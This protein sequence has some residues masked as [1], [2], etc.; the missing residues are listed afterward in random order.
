[1]KL[2]R[3]SVDYAD[4]SGPKGE[5]EN[6]FLGPDCIEIPLGL[7]NDFRPERSALATLAAEGFMNNPG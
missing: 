2:R 4:I 1:M 6:H 3:E 5:I 7:K